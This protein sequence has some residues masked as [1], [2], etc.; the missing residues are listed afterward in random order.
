MEI[1]QL[2][3]SRLAKPKLLPRGRDSVRRD[4]DSP[5]DVSLYA[6]LCASL[7]ADFH[8]LAAAQ[9]QRCVQVPSL[10]ALFVYSE[11]NPLL[12]AQVHIGIN[13]T[14]SNKPSES[15]TSSLRVRGDMAV[16][17]ILDK[18]RAAIVKWAAKVGVNP[19][20]AVQLGTIVTS[21][22]LFLFMHKLNTANL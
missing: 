14:P 22:W 19:S 6:S 10:L 7:C 15:R 3:I 9:P 21:T 1:S 17:I 16:E 12:F 20:T 13:E 8:W 11:S 2:M 18:A 4:S 5:T